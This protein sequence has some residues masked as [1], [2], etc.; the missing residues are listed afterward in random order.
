MRRA[1]CRVGIHDWAVVQFVYGGW[2]ECNRCG[3]RR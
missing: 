2:F 1:L 3:A